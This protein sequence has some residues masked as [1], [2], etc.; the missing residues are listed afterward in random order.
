[1][2][3]SSYSSLQLSEQDIM[4]REWQKIGASRTVLRCLFLI[5]VA[6]NEWD[7]YTCNAS[8][9]CGVFQLDSG[10]QAM[11]SYQDTAYWAA[12]AMKNGF[13]SH[14]GLIHI[15]ATN[16]GWSIGE[17]VQACQGAGP[18]WQAATDYYNGRLAEADAALAAT[19]GRLGAGAG[20]GHVPSHGPGSGPQIT[21][22]PAPVH[23]GA[24][25][26][27]PEGQQLQAAYQNYHDTLSKWNPGFRHQLQLLAH[28]P[29]GG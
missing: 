14:G 20:H 27:N 29:I 26:G 18:T 22:P 12:Y 28:R 17:M 23:S 1:M 21:S 11:H 15:A 3:A 25:N 2:F 6:E 9:H 24:W 10:W 19:E 5:G 16:P 13:Y 7:P 4:F 8:N